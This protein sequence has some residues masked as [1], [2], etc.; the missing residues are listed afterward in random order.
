LLDEDFIVRGVANTGVIPTKADL[1]MNYER[2]RTLVEKRM[3]K[4]GMAS[5]TCGVL[6]EVKNPRVQETT[7]RKVRML[8]PNGL[9]SSYSCYK[10]AASVLNVRDNYLFILIGIVIISG[11]F[12]SAKSQTAALIER[13]RDLAIIRVLGWR[14]Y[15]VSLLIMSECILQSFFGS[16]M[17]TVLSLILISMLPMGS[18]LES[19]P[20]TMLQVDITV[21]LGAISIIVVSGLIAGL[22]ASKS[23]LKEEPK[24]ILSRIG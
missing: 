6:I 11:V 16:V 3:T 20:G 23:V 21:F 1:Y 9:I 12:I 2:A 13:K 8:L 24:R 19:A 4:P 22:I 17:G 7:I 18:W 14:N 10:P 5:E 15:Q